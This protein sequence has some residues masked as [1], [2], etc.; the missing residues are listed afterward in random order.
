[1]SRQMRVRTMLA[2]T[3]HRV[4][5]WVYSCPRRPVAEAVQL[6]FDSVAQV[7]AHRTVERRGRC[8]ALERAVHPLSAFAAGNVAGDRL[9]FH[10]CAAASASLYRRPSDKCFHRGPILLYFPCSPSVTR[11]GAYP[12]PHHPITQTSRAGD[13]DSAARRGSA[14]HG[15]ERQQSNAR[16][17]SGPCAP[18]V[19]AFRKSLC[20]ERKR[21]SEPSE[22]DAAWPWER[23]TLAS[24]RAR[25]SRG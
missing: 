8:E 13:P 24:L 16:R 14:S 25:V 3:S 4:R 1:V 20:K 10:C 15:P 9:W 19:S 23:G 11:F 17:G 6:T 22:K 21:F 5:A 18:R 7:Q 12:A 2:R